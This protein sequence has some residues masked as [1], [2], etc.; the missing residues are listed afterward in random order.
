MNCQIQRTQVESESTGQPAVKPQTS[1]SKQITLPVTEKKD[2]LTAAQEKSPIEKKEATDKQETPSTETVSP[3]VKTETPKSVSTEKKQVVSTTEQGQAV[4]DRRPSQVQ[5]SLKPKPEI[6]TGTS[7]QEEAGKPTPQPPKSISPTAK[8]APPPATQPP[9]QQSG[10]FFGF[11]SPKTQPAKPSESV[12]GKMLGFG[13]SIFSSAS[14]LITSAVQD[15]PK[16]TPPTPRK[17]STPAQDPAKTTP[18]VSPAKKTEIP[19]QAKAAQLEKVKEEKGQP[20]PP[21]V[22]TKDRLSN[23]PLC[24]VELNIGTKDPPNYNNCTQCK[25]TVCNRC[26][27]NPMPHTGAVSPIKQIHMFIFYF[28]Y[29]SP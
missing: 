19:P 6:K 11:G 7:K 14:T 20:E 18:P 1:P 8:P 10:G 21:K 2:V 5:P 27:F 16:T 23:C 12:K 13:S 22:A 26:G 15:E 4:P 28:L 24:K 17:M 9:K 3:S 29:F 25:N